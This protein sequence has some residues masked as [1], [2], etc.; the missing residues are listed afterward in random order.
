L[1]ARHWSGAGDAERAFA[2]WRKAGEIGRA[3]NAFIEAQAAY[4]HALGMLAMT[5]PSLGR[6]TTELELLIA[7]S[8]MIAVTKGYTSSDRVEINARAEVLA[9][10][11]GN[12]GHLAEQIFGHGRR[13]S[14][15]ATILPPLPWPIDYSISRGATVAHSRAV[16]RAARSRTERSQ[17]AAR[18]VDVT[19]RPVRGL[20]RMTGSSATRRLR[21]VTN[22]P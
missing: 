13:W 2:A 18:R 19:R 5:P 1:I 3:R 7:M 14:A 9:T 12:L 20:V 17:G 4:R 8:Q 21:A 22:A 16:W 10:K 11:T 15:R 6:D